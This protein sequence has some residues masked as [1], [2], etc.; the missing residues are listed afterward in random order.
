MFKKAYTEDEVKKAVEKYAMDLFGQKFD[1][2][3]TVYRITPRT[4]FSKYD[5]ILMDSKN[6]PG[7]TITYRRGNGEDDISCD[8]MEVYYRE[9]HIRPMV[10]KY[11]TNLFGNVCIIFNCADHSYGPVNSEL[12]LNDFMK[13]TGVS[14][15]ILVKSEDFEKSGREFYENAVM[16]FLEEAKCRE[17]KYNRIT[18]G[19][20]DNIP[21]ERV[22]GTEQFKNKWEDKCKLLRYADFLSGEKEETKEKKWVVF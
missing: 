16:K 20:Y 4:M 10:E 1:D 14:F 7:S 15:E 5:Y 18:I 22:N 2:V 8:Y 3:I 11:F 21:S 6:M 13:K 9:L 12:T 19:V 17:W